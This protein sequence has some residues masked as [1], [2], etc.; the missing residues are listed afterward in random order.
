MAEEENFG[1]EAQALEVLEKEFND[2]LRGLAA[3][4]S[5]ERF[6]IEYDKLHQALKFSNDNQ[7][8]LL[9]KCR[10][11]SADI[12]GNVMKVTQA[13]QMTQE[14]TQTIATLKQEL[15]RVYKFLEASKQRE[16]NAKKKIENLQQEINHLNEL[17]HRGTKQGSGQTTLTDLTTQRNE[18]L[19]EK[20]ILLK[21]KQ[22]LLDDV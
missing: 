6:R 7:K 22:N 12:Q 19:K 8:R 5:L 3:D 16:E 17:I 2:V 10:E 4:Q 20:E 18:L 15:E 14:D 21:M 9:Q 11:L 1:I 13:L